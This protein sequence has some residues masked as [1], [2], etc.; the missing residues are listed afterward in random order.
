MSNDACIRISNLS[1][2]YVGQER[3]AL[4][5]LNL[6]VEKGEIFG[7]LGPNGAGKTTFFS[8]MCGLLIPTSGSVTIFGRSIKDDLEAIKPH[9][10]IVPQEVALY[11]DLSGRNNLLYVGRM[12]GVESKV[13]KDRIEEYLLLFNM[14]ESADVVVK[15]YSGGMKRKVNLIAGILHQPQVLLLDEPTVGVDIQTRM[16][17]IEF[18]KNLNKTQQTTILYTS[19]HLDEAQLFCDR[20]GII[21]K[22][23]L[24]RLGTPHAL[25]HEEGVASLE[26]VFLKLTN[27]PSF[28]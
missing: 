11:P 24:L 14:L 21:E 19:H 2:K 5:E 10:G 26:E 1:K 7:F 13:L 28:V 12:Y 18:L 8:I 3:F 20:V 27:S 15:K 23:Q 9:F 25:M 6:R 17:M 22:G 16:A 4:K